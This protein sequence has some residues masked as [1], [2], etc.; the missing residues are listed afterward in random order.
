MHGHFSCEI[1]DIERFT[2]AKELHIRFAVSYA[3]QGV[4]RDTELKFSI[5]AH[6]NKFQDKKI[7]TLLSHC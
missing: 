1:L 6:F 7:F 2:L 3:F 4:Q 5:Q